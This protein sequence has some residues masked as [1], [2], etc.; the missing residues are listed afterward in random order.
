MVCH[1]KKRRF[2]NNSML[3]IF[4][5]LFVFL[6]KLKLLCIRYIECIR[7]IGFHRSHYYYNL[8]N[9]LAIILTWLNTRKISELIKITNNKLVQNANALVL[10]NKYYFCRM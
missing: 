8:R 7:C 9:S 10:I 3:N 1:C 6:I 5:R 4:D 2:K